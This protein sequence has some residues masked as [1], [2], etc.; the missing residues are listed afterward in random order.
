[1]TAQCSIFAANVAVH[2]E[3]GSYQCSSESSR[4]TFCLKCGVFR[5]NDHM[6][7]KEAQIS[8]RR[9]PLPTEGPTLEKKLSKLS[10]NPGQVSKVVGV[11]FKTG[12]HSQTHSNK[13]IC[14][15]QIK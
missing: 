4:M 10:L 5:C 9:A 14:A 6:G 3:D 1:M 7:D 11:A 12:P 15:G 8:L 13:R 2:F